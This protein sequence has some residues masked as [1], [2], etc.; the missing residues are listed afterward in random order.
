M[1]DN[2]KD[3]A[4]SLEKMLND[5][6]DEDS[7]RLDIKLYQ[8]ATYVIGIENGDISKEQA[9]AQAKMIVEE[10]PEEPRAKEMLC[11]VLC[12]FGHITYLAHKKKD[13]YIDQAYKLYIQIQKQV[14]SPILYWIA[15]YIMSDWVVLQAE[16]MKPSERNEYLIRNLI[17]V[18]R[19][20]RPYVVLQI[21]ESCMTDLESYRDIFGE[22]LSFL[23]ENLEK[24]GELYDAFG[25]EEQVNAN[26]LIFERVYGE[27]IS[28]E[29]KQKQAR[30]RYLESVQRLDINRDATL[31]YDIDL[32]DFV[33]DVVKKIKAEQG[34]PERLTLV[35]EQNISFISN[36]YILQHSVN[37]HKRV[38]LCLHG[39]GGDKDSTVIQNLCPC[40][41]K[42][43]FDIFAFDWPAHGGSS[44]PDSELTVEN[45]LKYLRAIVTSLKRDYEEVDC[46]ATSFGGYL[47]TL[48][49]NENPD[50][51]SHLI[52]RSPALRMDRVFRSMIGEEAFEKMQADDMLE[53]GF[54]RK[55]LLD[56]SFYDGL[57]THNAFNSVPGNPE[58]ILIMQGDADDIVS[59]VDAR[60][61]AEKNHIRV[62]WFQG[63]D[64]RYKKPGEMEHI[65][66]VTRKFLTGETI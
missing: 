28:D 30:E 62:E 39:F 38:L 21:I 40:L 42:Y 9:V 17:S 14:E 65:L 49:R 55:M 33:H 18:D 41:W 26:R 35:A 50:V 58:S 2:T 27:I 66:L 7:I 36:K 19:R 54:E 53:L 59:P 15:Q 25:M 24:N 61:Y 4:G 51:F 60:S 63:T 64:H 6:N 5:I 32:R 46:F 45:C 47:A 23:E 11:I 44:E 52:L 8:L 57:V 43:G 48:Y 13:T 1:H 37:K 56:R 34:I 20:I 16:E 10:Y 22:E 3:V 12:F 31:C 29:K